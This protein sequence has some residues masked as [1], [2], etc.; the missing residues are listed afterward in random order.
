VA[1]VAEVAGGNTNP[2]NVDAL[3]P[4]PRY[5]RLR[6]LTPLFRPV[7]LPRFA[8]PPRGSGMISFASLTPGRRGFYNN[9]AF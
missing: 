5:T 8:D 6:G 1:D 4:R 2:L 3:N 7:G 9:K